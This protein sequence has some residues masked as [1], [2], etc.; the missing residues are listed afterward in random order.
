[1]SRSYVTVVGA[2]LV[3]LLSQGTL[4]AQGPPPLATAAQ[5]E[6]AFLKEKPYEEFKRKPKV[7]IK[8]EDEVEATPLLESK[9]KFFIREIK[10]VG[11][12]KFSTKTIKKSVQEYENKELTLNDLMELSNKI[13]ALYASKGYV[14]SQAYVPPQKVIDETVIIEVLEGEYGKIN[15]KGARYTKKSIV[16]KRLKKRPGTILDYNELRRDLSSLNANPDRIVEATILRGEQPRETDIEVMVRDRLP[17]HVGYELN[18][19]GNEATGIWRNVYTFR[20]TGLLGRDDDFNIKLI[21][22]NTGR[23]RGI[24][25]GYTIPA[26][27]SGTKI[28]A[29]FSH[30][31]SKVD[32]NYLEDINPIFKGWD[33]AST[34]TVYS[35]FIQHPIFNFNW[36]N[37]QM[38]VGIDFKEARSETLGIEQSHDRLRIL[39]TGMTTEQSDQ[40]GRTV[41]RNELHMAPSGFLGS[42]AEIYD[43]TDEY[44]PSANFLKYN[45]IFSRI[46]KLPLSA[47]LLLNVEGQVSNRPLFG[48]EQKQIGGVYTV[49]G[50]PEGEA[51]GDYGTNASAEIRFP[52]YPIPKELNLFGVNP[53]RAVQGVGFMDWGFVR[54][55]GSPETNG[56]EK[57]LVG[58]GLGLR[59]NLLNFISGRVDMAWPVGD[60][61]SAGRDPILHILCTIKEPTLREYERMR[62]DMKQNRI[63][64]KLHNLAKNVPADVIDSYEKALSLEKEGRYE[65]AKELFSSVVSRK[66]VIVSEAKAKINTMVENEEKA[67]AYLKEADMLFRNEN[68]IEAKE[69]YE[70]I[71]SIKKGEVI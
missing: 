8:R 45:F 7:D 25:G 53:R 36:L 27:E 52:L 69:V 2:G 56:N 71:L 21:H 28:G 18:N 42:L 5:E 64:R 6:E 43:T 41:V 67:E 29:I 58:A 33:I 63:R 10:I 32:R 46:N 35:F 54:P 16:E 34:S 49:R 62:D 1:M 70:K 66:N 15:V 14:T 68:Y 26:N 13:T 3:I 40:W 17:F 60:P 57:T 65:E 44:P 59:V 4:F 38:D 24:T 55:K 12:T 22:S 61:S 47:M 11:N 51:L 39:K 37:S 30:F 9:K 31:R 50:Y 48:S 23:V 20:N 19:T